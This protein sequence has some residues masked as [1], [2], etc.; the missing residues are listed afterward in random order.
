MSFNL[1]S[2]FANSQSKKQLEKNQKCKEILLA[3]DLVVADEGHKIKNDKS[4]L[5]KAVMMLKT[6]KRIILT[7]TPLQNNLY[8]PLFFN[9]F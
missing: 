1:F 8:S 9:H 4:S 7:G 6:P 5:Y 2:I 3:A